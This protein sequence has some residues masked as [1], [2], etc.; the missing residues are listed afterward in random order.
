M[1]DVAD[2][3]VEE[4]DRW[5]DQDPHFARVFAIE[6]HLDISQEQLYA[7]IYRKNARAQD[8]GPQFV[9]ACTVEICRNALGHF[10]IAILR[11]KSEV[12]R[13][14]QAPGFTPTVR[15]PQCGHTVWRMNFNFNDIVGGWK[16]VVS[17]SHHLSALPGPHKM[18]RV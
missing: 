17:T 7:E 6:M 14:Q 4:E 12:K 15:S 13:R 10:T 9:R 2:D 3:D 8:R 5:Q 1:M 16:L 11:G 18:F